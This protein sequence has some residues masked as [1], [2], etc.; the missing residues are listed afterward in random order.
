[1]SKYLKIVFGVLLIAVL[2]FGLIGTGAWF[3]SQVSSTNNSLTAATLNLTANGST[4]T[5][6]SYILSNI[7]PGDWANAGQVTLCNTGIIAGD[8]SYQIVNLSP[9]NGPLGALVYSEFQ[10]NVSPW[11]RYNTGDTF[12]NSVGTSVAVTK[13]DPGACLPIILDVSWPSSANDNSAQGAS[14]TFDVAWRLDQI[15]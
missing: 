5:T 12:N 15:H 4:G 11:A 1:M 8:L 14:L 10:E 9:A 3:S 7:K 6:G 2:A 13:L